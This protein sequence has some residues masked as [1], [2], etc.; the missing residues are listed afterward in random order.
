MALGSD[1]GFHSKSHPHHR[2]NTAPMGESVI[3]AV[4]LM[5]PNCDLTRRFREVTSWGEWLFI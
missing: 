1:A 5:A 4:E 2:A 3:R